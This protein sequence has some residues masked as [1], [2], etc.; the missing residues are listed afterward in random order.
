[1]VIIHEESAVAANSSHLPPFG[2]IC[3]AVAFY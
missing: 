1:V 2:R 3:A